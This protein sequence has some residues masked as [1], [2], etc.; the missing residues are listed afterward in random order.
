MTKKPSPKNLPLNTKK[1]LLDSAYG[2]VY[3]N[4]FTQKMFQAVCRYEKL[5]YEYCKLCET[6]ENSRIPF[7]PLKGSVIRKYYSKPWMRTSSDIDVL[8]DKE[9]LKNTVSCL[10]NNLG[11]VEKEQTAH[12][13]SLLS[14]EGQHIEIHFELIEEGKANNANQILKSVWDNA[15]LHDGCNYQYDMADEFFYFYHIAHI[16]KHFK[17]GGCGIRPFIDL[18]ILD[19]IAGADYQKR[20]SLLMQGSLLTFANVALKLSK[21][22]FDNEEHTEVTKQLEQF[23]LR[24]GEYGTTENRVAVKQHKKGSR[25]K[26]TFS[27]IFVPYNIIKYRYPILQKHR[28]LMPVMQIRRWG[29]L[30]K[31][32]V[33]KR[34]KNELSMIKN[35]SKS[36][37]GDMNSFLDEIGLL[38]N[39]NR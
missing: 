29:M 34:A 10:I 33:A 31:P 15:V 12:D 20:D 18:W 11:Y 27:R 6:L 8:V 21:I 5:N 1:Q 13:I 9:N 3:S 39:D 24:G 17:N 22:W 23:I 16:A 2:E 19:G 14:P 32:S 25:F 38:Y 37:A 26:Y 7:M 4:K 30:L 28:W 36:A 35:I